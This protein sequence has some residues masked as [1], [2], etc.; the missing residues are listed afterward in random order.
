MLVVQR[1]RVVN[2]A[3]VHQ[4]LTVKERKMGLEEESWQHKDMMVERTGKKLVSGAASK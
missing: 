2:Y 4:M 1:R 3:V